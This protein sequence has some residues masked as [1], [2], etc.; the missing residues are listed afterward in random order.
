MYG[1]DL[2]TIQCYILFVDS[3]QSFITLLTKFYL[4]DYCDIKLKPYRHQD[5]CLLFQVISL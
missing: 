4:Y 2:N 5:D 1:S 3:S